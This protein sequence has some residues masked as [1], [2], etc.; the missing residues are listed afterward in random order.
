[1][2]LSDHVVDFEKRSATKSHVLAD[3]IVDWTEHSSYTEG[4]MMEPGGSTKQERQQ[5]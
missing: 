2:E 3:F 4:T 1:M 5:Y